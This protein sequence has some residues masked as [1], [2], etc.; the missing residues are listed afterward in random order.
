[1]LLTTNPQSATTTSGTI[2]AAGS[3]GTR[4]G[5]AH[6]KVGSVASQVQRSLLGVKALFWLQEA[7]E[8]ASDPHLRKI[9]LT[10]PVPQTWKPC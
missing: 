3:L 8:V 9:V 1:M 5:A 6:L 2:G 7:P 4:V 10:C